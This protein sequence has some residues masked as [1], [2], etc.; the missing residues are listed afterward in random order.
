MAGFIQRTINTV[1]FRAL[2]MAFREIRALR[3]TLEVGIDTYRMVHQLPPVFQEVEVAEPLRAGQDPT[4]GRFIKPG[5]F[6][7]VDLIYQLCQQFRIPVD[8]ETDIEQLALDRG[9]VNEKGEFIV[10]PEGMER[11]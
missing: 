2:R 4:P 9:W 3:K 5:D 1:T 8:V 7:T 6:L 11:V 10:L